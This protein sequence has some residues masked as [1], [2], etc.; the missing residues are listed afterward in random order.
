[1][2]PSGILTLFK[3]ENAPGLH[4]TGSP[5]ASFQNYL[6]SK[7]YIGRTGYPI[8]ALS[9]IL[10]KSLPSRLKKASPI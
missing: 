4:F 10:V 6:Q 8:I 9:M 1:M 7:M 2:S 3:Y 5:G